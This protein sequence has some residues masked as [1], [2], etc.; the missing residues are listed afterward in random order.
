MG[1]R[2]GLDAAL[3]DV[4]VDIGLLEPDHPPEP[5]AGQLTLVEEAIERPGGDAQANIEAEVG[6]IGGGA[7]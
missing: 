4:R 2:T 3:L 1:H 5:V 6:R 7:P